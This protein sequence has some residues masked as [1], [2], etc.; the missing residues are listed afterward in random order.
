MI[1]QPLPL[2]T[3]GSVVSNYNGYGV[4][5]DGL[6]DGS[7]NVN[8]QGSNT[9]YSYLWSN[10]ANTSTQSALPAGMYT[11]LVT[12][13]LGCESTTTVSISEPNAVSY[14]YVIND[15]RCFNGSDGTAEIIPNGGVMPYQISWEDGSD[16]TY[17]DSLTSGYYMFS[18]QDENNCTVV[19]SIEIYQPT[20]ISV[21]IDTNQPTCVRINDGEINAFVSGGTYPYTYR[22]NNTPTLLP[23]DSA[24]A[25]SYVMTVVDSNSC[26]KS[27]AFDL[28]PL[29]TECFMISNMYSPNYDG[30]NDEFRIN[31][32]SW[33]SYT[34]KIYN[35]VGHLMYSG[36]ETTN[37]DGFSNG[38]PVPVGDYYYLLITD[39]GESIY[40]YVTL[41]R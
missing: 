22:V 23:I 17:I 39:E 40:G 28:T 38:E 10:G 16:S 24:A 5:C 41:I 32:S 14:A 9:P 7:I 27:I 30:Y 25:G 35:P 26:T 13:Y 34:V 3:T 36:N 20:D 21:I 29:Q 6:N 19:D 2:T 12:D 1:T 15:I 31:H 37:W 8:A 33:S 4:S 18:V 11:V